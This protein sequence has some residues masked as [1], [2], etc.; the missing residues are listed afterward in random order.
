M[1]DLKVLRK[2]AKKSKDPDALLHIRELLGEEK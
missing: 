1:R 2:K